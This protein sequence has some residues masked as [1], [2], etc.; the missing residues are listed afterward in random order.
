MTA[1]INFQKESCQCAR[2]SCQEIPGR[3]GFLPSRTISATRH[4]LHSVTPHS[5]C[6]LFFV[7]FYVCAS[8]PSSYI[9]LS[10]E[11]AVVNFTSD[12]C[13]GDDRGSDLEWRFV[14]FFFCHFPARSA[15]TVCSQRLWLGLCKPVVLPSNPSSQLGRK[16]QWS[17]GSTASGLIRWLTCE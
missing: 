15:H 14:T 8:P 7:L 4:R 17:S 3:E 13:C 10:Q 2:T 12:H 11:L 5:Y 1:N 9:L 6:F 16:R